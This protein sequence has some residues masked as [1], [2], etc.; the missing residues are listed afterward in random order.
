MFVFV[1]F[2]RLPMRQKRAEI[3]KLEGAQQR[4]RHPEQKQIGNGNAKQMQQHV[5]Q[6]RHAN[7]LLPG[8]VI[9]DK[10]H[11]PLEEIFMH[12]IVKIGILGTG[13]VFVMIPVF[14]Q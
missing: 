9:S 7:N 12:P 14:G 1:T 13:R 5:E 8:D 10:M 6:D 3:E 11:I 2:R 4:W